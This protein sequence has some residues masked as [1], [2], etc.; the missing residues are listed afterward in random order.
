VARG[1]R[2]G[3]A[4]AAALALP[5]ICSAETLFDAIRM[6]YETNPVLKGQQAQLRGTDETLVQARAGLGPQVAVTGTYGYEAARV[7]TPAAVSSSSATYQ[8]A[9]GAANVSLVQPLFTS[10]AAHAQIQAA[11]ANVAAGRQDLRQAEAELILSVVTAYMD[12]L[13]DREA[14]RILQSEIDA[15]DY[16]YRSTKLRGEIGDLTRTDIAQTESRLVQAKAEL[17]LAKGQLNASNAAY[18]NVVGQ[19]PGDLAP[20]PELPGLPQTADE[21]FALAD[22]NNPLLLAAIEGQTAADA[23]VRQA[24]AGYGPTVGLRL[25]A[26]IEPLQSYTPNLYNRSAS[27]QA[28]FSQPLYTSGMNSSKV[29]QAL[30]AANQAQYN[31]DTAR[32]NVVQTVA[33][34]WDQ[35]IASRSAIE[36][37]KREVELQTVA[38][39]GN[40]V[41]QKVGLRTTI[42]LLNAELELAQDQ[43]RLEQSQHDGY[44]ASAAVLAALGRLEAGRLEAGVKVYDPAVSARKVQDRY[45]APW[46]GAVDA[47]DSIL[48]G[49]AA[50][51]GKAA[52]P[53]VHPTVSSAE[54]LGLRPSESADPPAW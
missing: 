13:R 48:Y 17:V 14:L 24:K 50:P 51:A 11:K 2:R 21:A 44:V 39:Q 15:L 30:E 18:L 12:V 26:G 35:L 20:P 29:R 32:R 40:R 38:V 23:Q 42:D 3:A 49:P 6:A 31:V 43:I 53:P 19:N 47:I 10:G 27:V 16:E 22:K 5:S 28:V 36:M 37:Q 54:A 25:G 34:T 45:V 52:A 4:L 33:R 7:D 1:W 9:S 41:E 8:A 46:V